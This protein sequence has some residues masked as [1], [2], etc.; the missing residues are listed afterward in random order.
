MDVNLILG[1]TDGIQNFFAEVFGGNAWIATIIVSMIPLIE[2]KGGIVFGQNGDFFAEPLTKW[3]A[4]ACGIIA[5][6][7]VALILTFLLKP[8]FSW[9]K[10][11]K[12]FKKFVI[13]LEKSFRKKADK[14][15]TDKDGKEKKSGLKKMFGVFLFTAVPVPLTG[16]WTGTAIAVFL[17]LKW[18]QCLISAIAGD[19]VAGLIITL[20]SWIFSDWL[21]IVFYVI[22]G[23][24]AIVL[25]SM[26]I[27]MISDGRKERSSAAKNGQD[28]EPDN[29]NT[30]E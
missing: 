20:V 30:E 12:V 17:D 24:A 6:A 1:V 27:K 11:T 2:L 29:S 14:I 19:I 7:I 3:Q 26:I 5:G 4:F 15:E 21:N 10:R 8:I 13:R 25:I 18:W 9:L 23:I 28:I 22:L 16:V